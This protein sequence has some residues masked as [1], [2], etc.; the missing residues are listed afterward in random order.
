MPWT[1]NLLK[2]PHFAQRC[3]GLDLHHLQWICI[4]S[5]A[6]VS[7]CWPWMQSHC[8]I[9]CLLFDSIYLQK[10][11]QLGQNRSLKD[12]VEKNGLK[13]TKTCKDL[14]LPTSVMCVSKAW[15]ILKETVNCSCSLTLLNRF[16]FVLPS[17]YLYFPKHTSHFFY[18]I[19]FPLLHSHQSPVYLCFILLFSSVYSP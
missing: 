11:L 8:L 5:Q 18:C 3:L 16:T 13:K 10:L 14:I 7:F 17:T 6:L 4:C 9:I 2:L 1:R 12:K 15:L 19:M